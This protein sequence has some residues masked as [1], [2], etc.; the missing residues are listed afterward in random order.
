M[1]F[2]TITP[3]KIATKRKH[4]FLTLVN[5]KRHCGRNSKSRKDKLQFERV[6]RVRAKKNS[7][8]EQLELSSQQQRNVDHMPKLVQHS[9]IHKNGMEI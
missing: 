4:S 3:S 6:G 8:N 7:M 1:F 5:K 9:I 2:S